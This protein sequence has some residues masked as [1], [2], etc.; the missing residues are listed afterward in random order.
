MGLDRPRA[1]P[2]IPAGSCLHTSETRDGPTACALTTN[3]LAGPEGLP[4][5]L[6]ATPLAWGV[7]PRSDLRLG[8]SSHN[9]SG[10]SAT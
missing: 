8:G 4:I 7:A 9:R 3:Q 5:P 10:A 2:A 6:R 1:R